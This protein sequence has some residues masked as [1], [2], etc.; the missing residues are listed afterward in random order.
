MSKQKTKMLLSGNEAIARGI[1]EAGVDIAAAY[2]GTPSTEIMGTI[3]IFGKETGMHAEWSINEKVAFEVAL[4]ASWSGL[5]SFT[6]AKHVGLNVAADSFFTAALFGG[7]KGGFVMTIADDPSFHSSQNEQDTRMYA[8]AAHAICMEPSTPQE[9]LDMIKYA[10]EFSEKWESLVILRS[11]TRLSHSRGPVELGEIP[12]NKDNH[13]GEFVKD[14]AKFVCLPGNARRTKPLL[15]AKIEEL[16]YYACNSKWNVVE[17]GKD[18]LLIITSGVSYTYVKDAIQEMGINPTIYKIGFSNPLP[19]AKII[20]F[21]KKHPKCLIA[22]EVEP[23]LELN[24]KALAAENRIQ[25]KIYGRKER[26]I[27]IS[28]ELNPLI[29]IEAISKVMDKKVEGIDEKL[30]TLGEINEQLPNRPPELCAGCPH[31]ATYYAI[32]R[33]SRK[34]SLK[35]IMPGDI[36]C[37]TLGFMPPLN[38]VDTTVA[39]GASIGIANGIAQATNQVVIPVIGDST[40]FHTGIPPLINAIVNNAK[41]TLVIMDNRTTAMTGF[42][43]TPETGKGAFGDPTG[44]VTIEQ[45]V[46]GLGIKNLHIIDPYDLDNAI[47]VIGKTLDSGELSVIISRRDCA[48]EYIRKMRK[49][50][51][52]LDKYYTDEEICIGCRTCVR[53]FACPAITFDDEKK[54]SHVDESM[55]IGCGVCRILCPVDA[56]TKR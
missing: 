13:K 50:K 19:E 25:V 3:A 5:R 9:A 39:M 24:V 35:P 20:E 30:P 48:L 29:L 12:P 55:C 46:K 43:P 27:P 51:K 45:V 6:A 41:F 11:T 17:E 44:I 7:M 21:L 54:K 28:N 36:G 26:V 53:S 52:E 40:F 47:D 18:P 56:F 42:Q 2:P 15:L 4:G 33:A 49:A 1:L 10:Y 8:L 37:Y 34:R 16:K 14:P 32:K 38:S 31:R 23:Y 22:E